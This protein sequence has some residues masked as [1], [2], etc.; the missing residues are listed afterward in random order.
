VISNS[1]SFLRF[2]ATFSLVL[3]MGCAVVAAINIVIDPYDAFRIVRIHGFNEYKIDVGNDRLVKAHVMTEE[4][5]SG[6]ILGTS[7]AQF[8]FD[9]EYAE[10]K[11]LAPRFYNAG[12]LGANPY[13]LMRYLQHATTNNDIRVAILVVDLLMFDG[14]SKT[15]SALDAAFSEDRL[16][17]SVDGHVKKR[18][19]P[20]DFSTLVFSLDAL[21]MSLATVRKQTPEQQLLLNNGMRSPVNLDYEIAQKGGARGAFQASKHQYLDSYSNFQLFNDQGRSPSLEAF[22]AL[23]KYARAKNI[24]LFVVFPPVHALQIEILKA[25][26]RFENQE[27]LKRQILSRLMEESRGSGK[28]PFPLWDFSA[29]H[30]LTTEPVPVAKNPGLQMQ[31]FYDS[32]HFRPALGDIA[33]GRII[34]PEHASPH[35]FGVLLTPDNLEA[36]LAD[37][38][39]RQ[40]RYSQSHP[41]ELTEL[42]A[43]QQQINKPVTTPNSCRW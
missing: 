33:F 10:L 19:I 26:N 42:D 12:L 37:I 7:Q 34:D 13:Q 16:D 23:V 2:L 5:Y 31:R 25:T 27:C 32:A 6:V 20:A 30:E 15:R 35:D 36:S 39:S 24:K 41:A 38:R 1:N 28:A 21:R 8:C 40:D 18:L 4:K 17:I 14:N 22:S 43:I 11:K 29:A 9:P 3:A